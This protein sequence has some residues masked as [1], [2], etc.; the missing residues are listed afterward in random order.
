MGKMSDLDIERQEEQDQYDC[1]I[2]NIRR[3]RPS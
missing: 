2:D 1:D 3:A